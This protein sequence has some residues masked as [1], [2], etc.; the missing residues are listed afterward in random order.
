MANKYYQW[1]GVMWPEHYE[2]NDSAIQSLIDFGVKGYISPLHSDDG[3]KP[4]YHFIWCFDSAKTY[5]G[6]MQMI[7][8][9][10]LVGINTVRYVKDLTTRARYLTHRD[11]PDKA[12]Y[13]VDDVVCMG[14]TD[15]SQFL[16]VS[17]DKYN[18]DLTLMEVIDKYEIRSYA[19]LVKYCAYISREN[20]KSVVGRCGFWSAY[21]RS[22]ANDS[23][24]R[25]LENLI[26]ESRGKHEDL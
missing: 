10:N 16:Q 1:E 14:G 22:L 7:E 13:S 11:S 15:Y 12:L 3:G 8:D 4:H 17:S 2:D 24:S 9:D 6:V 5:E 26:N 19:Q 23:I 25:E 21:V 18:D 20:Y